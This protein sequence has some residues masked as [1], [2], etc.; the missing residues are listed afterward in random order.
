MRYTISFVLA[1][2]CAAPALAEV[3]KVMTDFAPVQSLVAQVMGDLGAPQVLLPRGGDAHDFQLRPSQTA[4]LAE[5]DLLVWIGPQMTP[6][7]ERTLEAVEPAAQMQLLDVAGTYLLPMAAGEED[8]H[9]HDHD[10]DHG[11]DHGEPVEGAADPHA[12]L[13]PSNAALWVEAIA[14]ALAARDPENAATYQ[15]NAS[16]AQAEIAALDQKIAA[17]LAPV[18]GKPFAVEHNAYRYFAGH[19]GLGEISAIR[20]GDAAPPG[21]AHLVQLRDQIVAGGVVCLFPEA[22]HDPKQAAQ[23]IEGTGVRLGGALD[24]EGA[25]LEQG[26]G[27][28]A[29]LMQGLA[30]GLAECM[31]AP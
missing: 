9:G 17:Q 3:P 8:A 1:S 7:L 21:A 11:H 14:D 31:G 29:T 5:A 20:S 23:L 30:T 12:W 24:P 4:G 6:W 2:L 16:K 18:Q 22:A 25:D 15:S 28:Y 13:D 27:L 19:Y 26:A 10:H